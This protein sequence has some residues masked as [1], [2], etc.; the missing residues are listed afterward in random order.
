MRRRARVRVHEKGGR[1]T[2]WKP[3]NGLRTVDFEAISK[4]RCAHGGARATDGDRKILRAHY[5]KTTT[6]AQRGGFGEV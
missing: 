6:V 4:R 3:V 5:R 2:D 1:R